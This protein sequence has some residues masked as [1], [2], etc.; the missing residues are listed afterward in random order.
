MVQPKRSAAVCTV[1]NPN[2]SIQS[3]DRVLPPNTRALV[4]RV[5]GDKWRFFV[6]S[7][8]LSRAVVTQKGTLGFFPTKQHYIAP[9]SSIELQGRGSVEIHVTNLDGANNAQVKTWEAGYL[10]GGLE[11]VEFA[12]DG[13]TTPA[14]AAFGNLGSFGGFPAPFTN[15][16]R[17][18]V[19]ALQTR[20][21]AT[22]PNGLVILNAGPQPVDER[23]YIDLDT[24][25]G[26]K[27]EIRESTAGAGINYGVIWYRG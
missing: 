22:A 10:C 16:C 18:Y 19:D 23:L 24:P 25:Q 14:A 11:P 12:E 6:T 7:D 27:F 20:I 21:R 9:N 1:T 26:Y 17:L 2:P 4:A 13:L 5:D 8:R 15:H 3:F